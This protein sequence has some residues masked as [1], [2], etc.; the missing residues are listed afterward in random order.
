MRSFLIFVSSLADW[1]EAIRREVHPKAI[2]DHNEIETS[3]IKYIKLNQ[4]CGRN[5]FLLDDQLILKKSLNC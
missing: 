2:L 5:L 3:F 1:L 4:L